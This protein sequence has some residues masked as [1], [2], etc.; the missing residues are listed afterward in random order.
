MKIF[1]GFWS[2]VTI[3]LWLILG[4]HSGGAQTVVVPTESQNV[5][6]DGG[7]GILGNIVREQDVYGASYFS[8]GP[9]VITEL[10]FRP[11]NGISSFSTTVSNIQITLSTTLA[12][13]NALS[14][15]FANNVGSNAL[16]VYSGILPI[17]SAFTGPSG[18]PKAFDISIPL[19]HPFFYNPGA[20]NLLM[21]IQN[22]TGA[23]AVSGLNFGNLVDGIGSSSDKAS[24]SIA[25]SPTATTG[26]P[27]SGASILQVVAGGTIT[28]DLSKDFSTNSNPNGVWS[29]GYKTNLTGPFSLVT[30]RGTGSTANGVPLIAWNNGGTYPAF[31]FNAT[32]STGIVNNSHGA[33]GYFFPGTLVFSA[34]VDGAPEN[35]GAI[36]FK[37]PTNGSGTYRLE[38]AVQSLYADNTSGDTDY[39]VLVN[40]T[41]VFGQFVPANSAAGYTNLVTLASGDTIDFLAGRGADGLLNDSQLKIQATLTLAPGPQ[42]SLLNVNFGGTNKTG[43]AAFGL[44]ASDYWNSYNQPAS[45]NGFLTNL[46]YA[47]GSNSAV[48]MNVTNAPGYFSITSGG[49]T[50]DAMYRTYVYAFGANLTVVLTNLPPGTN[51][52]YL[53]GH[54]DSDSQNGIFQVTSGTNTYGPSQTATNSSWNSINWL[55]NAQYVVF[56]NV[57]VASNQAVRITVLQDSAG[58]AIINGMQILAPLP[59]APPAILTQPQNLT[60]IV[61][62]NA[63]LSVSATGTAPL[64]YQWRFSGTN[65]VG[66]TNSTLVITNVMPSLGGA[67]S[68]VVTNIGGSVTS[69][70]ATVKVQVLAVSGNNVLLTNFTNSYVGT[71]SVRLTNYFPNGS[72]FYTLDGSAPTFSSSQFTGPFNI[73]SSSLLRTR[74]Y[75]ADFSQSAEGDLFT[76]LITPVYTLTVSTSGGGGSVARNPSSSTYVSNSTVIVTATAS[77]GWTFLGWLGDSTAVT[78]N[79]TVTMNKNKSLQ[80]VFGTG[81]GTTVAG[82]G[83]LTIAPAAALYPYGATAQITATAQAG[84]YFAVWGNAASGN[85]S[86]NPLLFVITNANPTVSS[87][88]SALNPGEFALNLGVSGS[89]RVSANPQQAT[90]SS[91]QSVVLTATPATNQIFLGWSGDATGT[92]NPLL[93]SMTQTKSITA[94]FTHGPKLTL[95]GTTS[96]A[97]DG[98]RVTL[99]GDLGSKYE[100]DGSSNLVNW[101][102]LVTLTNS[103][104]VIQF[105]DPAATNTMFRFYRSLLIP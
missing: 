9:I 73:V 64:S 3:S 70:V 45:P 78:T 38:S 93:I 32:T 53:Y 62:S 42:V 79:V 30:T 61:G 50:N 19:Q 96:L 69:Q 1:R 31:L 28:Y 2:Q 24:R 82:N 12:V 98:F 41:E 68:A 44:G 72:T 84:N 74:A 26:S 35:Y 87:L 60:V 39:H 40:A 65:L 66:S 75:S 76:F 23:P 97:D 58:Y 14:T 13:P 100:I 8:N 71:V 59:P 83:S 56:R 85:G 99:G 52:F 36:R 47:S 51:D 17:S 55:E 48:G 103:S 90:Y 11:Y 105:T 104:G 89:G 63:T 18:G 77:N 92:Q 29:Y 80:A 20:G 102:P 6:G 81:L 43:Q 15:T 27:D 21:D 91:G 46:L 57:V 33:P 10:R 86:A 22:F 16:V 34:G 101:I 7:T 25:F 88:F 4:I 37:V 5:T 67:Y 94:S 49:A 95:N 54:G